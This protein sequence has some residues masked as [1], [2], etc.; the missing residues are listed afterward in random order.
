MADQLQQM[1]AQQMQQLAQAM[2]NKPSFL[3][4]VIPLEWN[5]QGPFALQTVGI[6]SKPIVQMQ[7]T[8]KAG[9]LGDKFLQACAGSLEDFKKCAADAG[10]MYAGNVT[11]GEPVISGIP[12]GAGG[13]GMEIG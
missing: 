6:G 4:G 8:G 9:G 10:V 5:G 3:F 1:A 7:G 12:M 2:G 11:N 13:A